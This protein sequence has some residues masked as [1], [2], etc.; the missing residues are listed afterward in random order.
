MPPRTRRLRFAGHAVT[1]VVVAHDGARWLDDLLA[2]LAVQSRPPQ[3]VVAVD[4]GS[5]DSSP[6]VL[7]AAL[8][9]SAVIRV[10]RDASLGAAVQAGLDAFGGAP[11]PPGIDQDAREWVWLLHDDCAPDADALERLLQRADASGSIVAVGPKVLSWD[12]RHLVEVGVTVDSS[13][14]RQSGLE[15]REVD[16]GQH[17]GVDDVLAVGTA[18][19]LIRRDV[20]DS[21][22][23]LDR[24]WAVH[25]D[26]V[27]LGWRLN[28][29]GGR[30]VVASDAVIRHAAALTGGLRSSDATSLPRG[31][32]ARLHGM[33][34]VLANT[35]RWLVLPLAL[36][37]PVESILRAVLGVLVWRSPARARDEVVAI[38]AL[39]TRPHVVISA[40]RRRAQLRRR[41]HHELRPLL[42]PA[43]WRWRR[44]ADVIAGAFAGRDALAERRRRR[45]PVET[46]PV[47][48]EAESF[49]V[50][51][52]GV[53]AR[54]FTRPGVVVVVA[55]TVLALVADR[56]LF[57][58]V[59]HGGRLLPAPGGAS[60]LWSDYLAGWHSV[61]LG[62]TTPTPPW[63]AVLA[64][65]STVLLG[66]AWLAIDVI[67][68]GAVPLTALTAYV[69]LRPAVR[70]WP[71]R[72]WATVA[73]AMTP[74]LT[75]AVAGGR[76]ETL[77][78]LVLLP[79]AIRASVKALGTPATGSG[80]HRCIAAGLLLA[81]AASFAPI[82]WVTAVGVLVVTTFVFAGAP[83]PKRLLRASVL[84]AVA[85][86]VLL[87]WT[88]HVVTHP[89]L[90]VSGIGVSDSFAVRRG[91]EPLEL[92]LAHPGG[93]AQ[94]PLWV[95]GPIVVAAVVAVAF[96]RQL[97]RAGFII[98]AAGLI[99]AVV[100][101]RLAAWSAV[102]NARYWTGATLAVAAAGAV[103]AAAVA[104]DELP[105]ALAR[106]SFSWRQPAAAIVAVAAVAGVATAA[107][108]WLTR[109]A[110]RPLTSASASVLPVFAQAEAA[111]PTAPR[112]LVVR[113]GPVLRYA[114]LR[115]AGVHLPDADLDA[116][117]SRSAPLRLSAAVADAAVGRN[118]AL[119]E[120]TEFGVRLVVVPDRA[121]ASL[122]RLADVDGLTRVPATTTVVYRST[123][124]AG[125]VVLLSGKDATTA[126]SG[127]LLP[128]TAQP[129]AVNATAGHASVDV[130]AAATTRL[131]VLA[132]PHSRAWRATLDGHRLPATT[133]YGWA[134]AWRMPPDG[135]H[136]VVSR[137]EP[138]RAAWLVVE[139]IAVVVTLLLAVP[140]RRS[141]S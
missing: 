45:A 82:V 140:G 80:L 42:A 88:A 27:D 105:R 15:P 125:E 66:K 47:A 115:T 36:R 40:R 127:A 111:A 13:G 84:V 126:A 24:T 60:D 46:G 110:D 37:Y 77:A 73:Y 55:L 44:A 96:A 94:P 6:A 118:Q 54:F 64:L 18:G 116:P 52:L 48:D 83:L 10:P 39:V 102:A 29:Q 103:L 59:L 86:I 92:L 33:Q 114:T 65:L 136:L 61:G 134:Q 132:E 121:D 20:W 108:A 16:Q 123:M 91:V 87:P 128:S 53:V 22:G 35:S 131:V 19:L 122:A 23:G 89:R 104:A 106:R 97:A 32:A 69:A 78:V 74:V 109:G 26:D 9:E 117:T 1:A 71:V 101:S 56:A 34:L 30:V 14:G 98:F 62:S 129:V 137:S 95:W 3:R 57:G 130:A 135:G 28:A 50:D 141:E 43:S 63:V 79:L 25:G 67:V 85:P 2:G 113:G 31:A 76:L 17:D 112:T 70:R 11:A 8:G 58:D 90:L 100:Q 72:A 99:A 12:R 124:S 138:G 119:G 93:P 107:V 139:L 21:V 120:L 51:D 133:A 4:T 75:G 41:P 49:A 81:L 68:L 38:A 7:A 5:N